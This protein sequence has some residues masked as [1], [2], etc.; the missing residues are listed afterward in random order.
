MQKNINESDIYKNRY[1]SLSQTNSASAS[2][3]S[4]RFSFIIGDTLTSAPNEWTS[5][6]AEIVVRKLSIS[7]SERLWIFRNVNSSSSSSSELP[8][9]FS[10][11]ALSFFVRAAVCATWSKHFTQTVENPSRVRLNSV[12]S[13]DFSFRQRGHLFVGP[14]IDASRSRRLLR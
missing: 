11:P 10:L 12:A 7:I 9:G 3:H 14:P 13:S 6:V 1:L 5:S 4:R 2:A 8:S